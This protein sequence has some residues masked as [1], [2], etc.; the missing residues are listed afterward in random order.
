[1]CK[2]YLETKVDQ[3]SLPVYQ[4]DGHGKKEESQVV[5][6]TINHNITPA[7]NISNVIVMHGA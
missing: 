2:K 6:V 3:N 7:F 1:M 5:S 4:K